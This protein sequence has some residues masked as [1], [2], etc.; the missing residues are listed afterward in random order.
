MAETPD[1]IISDIRRIQKDAREN[2]KTE[3]PMI[4]F[5]SPKG[6]TRPKSGDG[7][8]TE[9]YWRSHQ[10]FLSEVRSN[11]KH[12]R[13]LEKWM[14]SYKPEDHPRQFPC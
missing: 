12:I 10:V 7:K 9:N 2:G 6:W 5:R 14:K 8:K 1:E 4:V 13:I 11:P 3:R